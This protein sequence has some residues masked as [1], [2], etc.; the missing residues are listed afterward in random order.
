MTGPPE[1]PDAL[2]HDSVVTPETPPVHPIVAFTD[3]DLARLLD[4]VARITL[5]L[6]VVAALVLWPVL[7]WQTAALFAVGA[8]ISVASVW[9]W[10]RLVRIFNARMDRQQTPRGSALVVI[11]FLIRL[12]LFGGAIYVS[13]KCLHG[14]PIALLSGLALAV[15]GLAWESLKLLRS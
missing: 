2:E 4:N 8:A 5:I 15:A 12:I 14:S 3:A 7:G 1:S 13:L 10:K 9:E 6:G 11:L